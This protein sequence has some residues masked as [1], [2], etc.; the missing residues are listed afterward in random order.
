MW[1]A[2]FTTASQGSFS[3]LSVVHFVPDELHS[4]H[5]SCE[6]IPGPWYLPGLHW[7]VH[8]KRWLLCYPCTYPRKQL[9]VL[10]LGSLSRSVK[11]LHAKEKSSSPI[12]SYDP[13]EPLTSMKPPP[14]I[15]LCCIAR[16]INHWFMIQADSWT[17]MSHQH[18]TLCQRGH[19]LH[20][21][22]VTWSVTKPRWYED[23]DSLPVSAAQFQFRYIFYFHSIPLLNFQS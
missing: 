5:I 9:L 23:L 14:P 17:H 21:P 18:I 4:L 13:S 8:R 15:P 12:D 19:L 7:Q 6:D 16:R 2:G 10:F 3:M 20:Y 11:E 1:A 22:V